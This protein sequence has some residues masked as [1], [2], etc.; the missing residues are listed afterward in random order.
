MY[1]KK[2]FKNHCANAAI[3]ALRGKNLGKVELKVRIAD[4]Y[5]VDVEDAEIAIR[6]VVALL[7]LN[8]YFMY[9][10]GKPLIDAKARDLADLKS[11]QVRY[12]AWRSGSRK[13]SFKALTTSIDFVS[14]NLK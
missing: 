6:R 12:D 13:V 3:L 11:N 8:E 1:H 4:V 14:N 10:F 5:G 7:C 2:A 9:V